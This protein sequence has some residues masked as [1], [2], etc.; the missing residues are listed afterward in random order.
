MVYADVHVSASP[1][2]DVGDLQQ[3]LIL[4]PDD[5]AGEDAPPSGEAELDQ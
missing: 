1:S 2:R 5:P 3:Q 4:Q